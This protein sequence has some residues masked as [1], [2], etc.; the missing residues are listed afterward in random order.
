MT[1]KMQEELFEAQLNPRN[2][3]VKIELPVL[4]G[5]DALRFVGL[6]TRITDAVWTTYFMEMN[7]IIRDGNPDFCR[8]L[9]R[10]PKLDDDE[11]FS[12]FNIDDLPF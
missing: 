1:D 7:E 2:V 5:Y 9:P 8:F 3:K 10:T 12:D 6:L 11:D 4:D